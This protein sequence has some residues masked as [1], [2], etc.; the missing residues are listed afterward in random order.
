MSHYLV[1][2]MP[3]EENGHAA[4][5]WHHIFERGGGEQ[6][7]RFVFDTVNQEIVA[8]FVVGGT[9]VTSGSDVAETWWA[10]LSPHLA[11]DVQES[12]ID[13]LGLAESAPELYKDP[14]FGLIETDIL[15]DWAEAQSPTPTAPAPA[16]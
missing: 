1:S 15:P 7:V 10:E 5:L 2:D 3:S 8:A 12:V 9:T 6:P 4:A 13:N 16:P 14:V 11:F